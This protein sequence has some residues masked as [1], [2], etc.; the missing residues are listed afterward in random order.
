KLN[1]GGAENTRVTSNSGAPAPSREQVAD[2]QN[3]SAED[4]SAMIKSMVERLAERLESE[5]EDI[6]GW[7]RLARSYNV[8]GKPEKARDALAKAVEGA[9]NNV[10][11][12]VLYARAA[13][14]TNGDQNTSESLTALRK[15]L[16]LQPKNIEALWFVGDAEAKAGNTNTARTLWRRA[17]TALPENTPDHAAFEKRLNTLK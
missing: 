14:A 7:T 1:D 4:R 9:P 16:T 2:A 3:M 13:R 11:L 5:P 15:A 8:L 10:E 12:L 17:L 6:E